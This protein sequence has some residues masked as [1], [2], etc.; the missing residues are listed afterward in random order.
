MVID[1][2]AL[3]VLLGGE[4]ETAK[5]VAAIAAASSRVVSAPTYLEA[6]IVT[7]ARWGAQAQEKFDRLLANLAIE[8]LPFTHDQ[9]ILAATAYRQYG[10][11]SGHAAGLN[12]GD[13]FSYALAKLRDDPLLFKGNDFSHTDLRAAV[14]F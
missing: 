6:A 11:G 5:F 13:C 9:A 8:I 12:F 14:T 4:L 7:S 3:I 2:S 10:K 1:S